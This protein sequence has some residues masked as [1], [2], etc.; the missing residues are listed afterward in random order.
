MTLVWHD[1]GDGKWRAPAASFREETRWIEVSGEYVI[2]QLGGDIASRRFSVAHQTEMGSTMLGIRG[3]LGGAHKLAEDHYGRLCESRRKQP[4]DIISMLDFDTH[5]LRWFELPMSVRRKWWRATNGNTT[6]AS[7]EFLAKL[8][9]LLA[10]AES[11]LRETKH[12]IASDIAAAQKL[13]ERARLPP[14]ERCLRPHSPCRLRCLRSLRMSEAEAVAAEAARPSD[15][16]GS[17]A[18][19]S[20][21]AA[22]PTL[23][24]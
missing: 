12:E 21:T 17:V 22:V 15:K 16:P 11:K 13:L 3:T 2:R 7:T 4:H 19:T 9:A 24:S 5:H 20:E 18:M 14:C 23:E 8:P 6:P 1:D 10:S